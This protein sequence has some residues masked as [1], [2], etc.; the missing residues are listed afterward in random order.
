M[1]GNFISSMNSRQGSTQSPQLFQ[2]S[3]RFFDLHISDLVGISVFTCHFVQFLYLLG[4][5]DT[6]PARQKE[7][8]LVQAISL[9][10]SLR[11]YH[12]GFT[13]KTFDVLDKKNP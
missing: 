9:L 11:V 3:V 10:W 1:I 7:G 8:K 2:G 13:E 4:E 5:D 6:S 12:H